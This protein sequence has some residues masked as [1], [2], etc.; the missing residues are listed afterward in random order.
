MKTNREHMTVLLL[1]DQPLIALDTEEIFRQAGFA[2]IVH[3]AS[4][5][6]ALDWLAASEPDLAIIETT[7]QNEPSVAFAEHLTRRNVP[8]LVYSGADRALI[9][10]PIFH[11]AEWVSKPTEVEMFEPAIRRVLGAS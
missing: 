2:R 3:F 7:L 4:V 8:L 6:A 1:E 9:G 10:E 11:D 5:A